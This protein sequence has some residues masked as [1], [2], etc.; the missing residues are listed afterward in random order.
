MNPSTA[1]AAACVIDFRLVSR[2]SARHFTPRSVA[3]RTMCPNACCAMLSAINMSKEYTWSIEVASSIVQF[4]ADR[5]N[6]RLLSMA[7]SPH[8]DTSLKCA[9]STL[10]CG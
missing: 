4:G 5:T 3:D 9:T 6:G 1:K 2:S 8:R 7:L 10:N